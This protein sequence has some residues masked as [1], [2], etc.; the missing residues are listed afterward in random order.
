MYTW[1]CLCGSA[2]ARV[3]DL[4]YLQEAIENGP[5]SSLRIEHRWNSGKGQWGEET[6]E[7][8]GRE[9]GRSQGGREGGR[10]RK[11]SSGEE[12]MQRN[13]DEVKM[14]LILI[15]SCSG[16]SS[17]SSPRHVPNHG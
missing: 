13:N 15:K 12:D 1:V 8:G 9:V 17:S 14:C 3:S 7:E 16:C 10:R 5:A 11:E 6:E 4:H 2:C